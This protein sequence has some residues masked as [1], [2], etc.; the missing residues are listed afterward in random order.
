MSDQNQPGE[1]HSSNPILD[2]IKSVQQSLDVRHSENTGHLA[3]L[4]KKVD[5]VL[6][7]FP[8][9]DPLSH[10]KFHEALIDKAKA[11]EKFWNDLRAKLIERGIWAT[12][13]LLGSLM[14]AG[15]AVAWK[16]LGEK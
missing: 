1:R 12:L 9:G 3:A 11:R 15:A 14:I 8:D 6:A 4:E 13:L 5:K 2:A 16:N 10:R 7:G